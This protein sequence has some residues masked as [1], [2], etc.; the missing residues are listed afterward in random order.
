MTVFKLCAARDFTVVDKGL[1]FTTSK[2]LQ[3]KLKCSFE[4]IADVACLAVS[5]CSVSKL[6]LTKACNQP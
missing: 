1:Q 2:N 5:H 3:D 6:C 4:N